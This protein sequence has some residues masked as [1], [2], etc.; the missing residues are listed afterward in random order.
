MKM[1]FPTDNH[2]KRFVWMHVALLLL[3][4]LCFSYSSVYAGNIPKETPRTQKGLH[5]LS[6]FEGGKL[7]SGGNFHVLELSGTYRQMGRQYGRLLSAPMK[8]LYSEVIRQYA[9]NGITCSDISLEDFSKQLFGLYPRRF[10]ELASGMS[11]TS[12]LDLNK[13]AV[14]NEYFDYILKSHAPMGSGNNG[15]CSAISVWDRYTKD[16]T[17]IMG[18]NFDFP[19]FYRAFN[20]YITVVAYNPSDST[21]STAVLTYAG[22]I[23][24]MQVFNSRGLVLEN[25]DGSSSGD[26]MRY[27]GKRVP[28]MAKD[29]SVMQENSTYEGLDAALVTSRMHYP[30]IYNVAYPDGAFTYEMTTFDVKRRQGQDGLLIGT[31]H[32]ISPGWDPPPSQYKDGIANSRKRYDNLHALGEKHKGRID[33]STMMTILDLPDDQG[34]ATPQDRCIYQFIAQPANMKIWIKAPTYSDWTE[35]DL[36]VLL[37]K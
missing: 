21:N 8:E 13:I 30:L 36:K 9:K 20:K 12:G 34:G 14:L 25:N 31:N 19:A 26:P 7:Y 37:H 2:I 28:F 22:Q 10:Q 32:F 4:V 15:N 33:V 6:T 27:F 3:A 35:V 23:S 11:E 17:L 1:I 29:L 5:L 16:K 18:R 24:S